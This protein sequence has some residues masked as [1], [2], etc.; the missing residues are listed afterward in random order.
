[1]KFWRKNL[2]ELDDPILRYFGVA[3]SA[4]HILSAI[5]YI[6]HSAVEILASEAPVCWPFLP[7]CFDRVPWS[8]TE[9]YAYMAIYGLAAA[10]SGVFFLKSRIALGWSF[11]LLSLVLKSVLLFQDYRMMGN[12]HYMVNIIQI[13]FLFWPGKR[14][15]IQWMTI[16]FY[17]SA[18]TLKF[19]FEWLSGAALL[20]EP[21]VKGWL[22]VAMCS[23]V[24]LLE[25]V[26]VF[27]LLSNRRSVFWMTMAQLFLFHLYSFGQVGY[28][29]PCVM[30]ALLSI[31]YLPKIFS[32][33]VSSL[34]SKIIGWKTVIPMVVFAFAQAAPL[35]FAGPSALTG[36]GRIFSL[37]M[38]DARTDCAISEVARFKTL[39]VETELKFQYMRIRCDPVTVIGLERSRCATLRRV[40]K[41]FVDIDV[42]M[43]SKINSGS[44]SA[45][46]RVKNFCQR[47]LRFNIWKPNE[48]INF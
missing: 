31:F 18:G 29:Y 32:F 8:A 35:A 1:M 43:N 20:E 48:Y 42:Y 19:N 4:I 33:E 27:G 30:F 45:I 34:D 37:N 38:F 13:L 41:D 9:T 26:F 12:Y 36:Q 2:N 3:L 17:V 10:A 39:T 46:L 40:R 22:L 14:R 5:F 7:N 24:V 15:A 47:D 28:F 21:H 44:P 6:Q 25:M 23:Y 11:S 16:G